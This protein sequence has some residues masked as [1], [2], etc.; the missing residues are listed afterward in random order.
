VDDPDLLTAR[1]LKQSAE[2]LGLF[3]ETLAEEIGKIPPVETAEQYRN[4]IM[5]LL[6]KLAAQYQSMADEDA[7]EVKRLGG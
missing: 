1:L 4:R 7:V 3:C 5:H 6:K 2:R